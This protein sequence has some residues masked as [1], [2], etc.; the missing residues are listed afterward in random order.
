MRAGRD[1]SNDQK[2]GETCFGRDRRTW[3]GKRRENLGS[4][5]GR[6][7]DLYRGRAVLLDTWWDARRSLAAQYKK[8]FTVS[9]SDIG[10]STSWLETPMCQIKGLACNTIVYQARRRRPRAVLSEERFAGT[11]LATLIVRC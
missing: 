6:R 7:D 8:H 11:S 3:M 1:G 9:G 5:E 10:C 2:M 4:H